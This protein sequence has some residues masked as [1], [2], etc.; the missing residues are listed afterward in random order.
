MFDKEK[1]ARYLDSHARAKSARKC[2]EY[3][4]EALEAGGMVTS[5]LLKNPWR[6]GL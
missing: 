6:L 5:S 2:A 4:R 1:F 3:V